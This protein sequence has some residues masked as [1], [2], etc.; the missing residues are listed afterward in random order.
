MAI[1]P[2]TYSLFNQ[3]NFD[4]YD[5]DA[6]RYPAVLKAG[7]AQHGL[8]L[9]DVL[10][11]TA[12]M[13]MW[14]I[15]TA[16]VFHGSLRGMFKKRVEVERLIAYSEVTQMQ[17]VR[18]GPHSARIVLFGGGSKEL[19]RID[20]SAAGM[21]NTPELAAAHRRRIYQILQRATA[22]GLISRGGRA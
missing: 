1:D 19:A 9:S 3:S 17:E 16:G 14:A 15:C 18:S 10:A 2:D 21:N 4:A 20:F 12:D 22:R 5:S 6:D 11:V 8:D 13:G 7:I